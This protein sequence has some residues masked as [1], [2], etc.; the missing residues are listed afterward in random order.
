[1][2]TATLSP[3]A[4][5]TDSTVPATGNATAAWVTGSIVATAWSTWSTELVA[6]VAV[7]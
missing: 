7:R 5:S 1:M 3:T 2:P 6:A 4:T